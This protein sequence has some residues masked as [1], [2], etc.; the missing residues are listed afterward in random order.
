MRSTERRV[1]FAISAFPSAGA[2]RSSGARSG[3]PSSGG[4]TRRDR[5]FREDIFDPF[6]YEAIGF[7]IR[8]RRRRPAIIR[9]ARFER[10]RTVRHNSV[11]SSAS[12]AGFPDEV[13]VLC[14][15][16]GRVGAERVEG[17]TAAQNE[18]KVTAFGATPPLARASA[19]DGCP[20]FADLRH[21]DLRPGEP[22][23]DQLDEGERNEGGDGARS[24][25]LAP[26]RAEGAG[27]RE[28]GEWD[29]RGR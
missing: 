28:R 8:G 9:G 2:A 11:C 18:R 25:P 20:C 17:H 10:E 5:L 22:P 3:R 24:R 19:K 4:S 7:L 23:E 26:I 1:K 6:D 14:S 21:H 12:R 29:H 16:K 15:A 13:V 27:L